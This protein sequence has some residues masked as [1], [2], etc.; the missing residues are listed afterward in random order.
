MVGGSIGG[1]DRQWSPD[2]SQ[3]LGCEQVRNV[4]EV[5]VGGQR[6][7]GYGRL[8]KARSSLLNSGASVRG[9]TGARLCRRTRSSAITILAAR[10]PATARTSALRANPMPDN[11]LGAEVTAEVTPPDARIERTIRMLSDRWARRSGE[12]GVPATVP[13]A[14]TG[15][16]ERE[17]SPSAPS[18]RPAT[19]PEQR[20]QSSRSADGATTASDCGR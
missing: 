3:R 14:L 18:A 13:P 7:R 8:R 16:P 15:G 17:R 9:A 12:C 6:P 4:P 1:V 5:P 19:E 11:G 2:T 10:V 20:Q